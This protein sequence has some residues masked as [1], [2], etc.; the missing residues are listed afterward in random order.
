MSLPQMSFETRIHSLGRVIKL[1]A[2][3][4][5]RFPSSDVAVMRERRNMPCPVASVTHSPDWAP[6]MFSFV[7]S[8]PPKASWCRTVDMDGIFKKN[9][10]CVSEKNKVKFRFLIVLCRSLFLA[11]GSKLE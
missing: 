3:D 4:T 1:T 9:L 8:H 10:R 2:G 5:F 11:F 7:S 6:V